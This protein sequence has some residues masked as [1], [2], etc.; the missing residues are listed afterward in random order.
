[1]GLFRDE[2]EPS[3]TPLKSSRKI[4]RTSLQGTLQK[5]SVVLTCLDSKRK[6]AKNLIVRDQISDHS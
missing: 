5:A 1:M 6:R 4:R 3:K 2:I